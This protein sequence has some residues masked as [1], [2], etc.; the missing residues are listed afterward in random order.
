MGNVSPR[1]HASDAGQAAEHAYRCIREQILSGERSGGEWLREDGLAE[2]IGVSRTPVRE[3]L[4]HLAAEGLVLY[5][6]NR[7]VQVQTWTMS[8]LNEIYGLRSVLEPYGCRLAATSGR[9]DLEALSAMNSDM[10][11]AANATQPDLDR[12]TE[13]N[14]DFHRLIIDASGNARL[15]DLVTSNLQVPLVRHTFSRYSRSS[16]QRSMAHHRELVDA[17]RAE[18]PDWAESVM[19]SHVHAAW[20]VMRRYFDKSGPEA[21]TGQSLE[22]PNQPPPEEAAAVPGS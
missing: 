15:G 14:N 6:R 10:E 18:D 13:L 22:S 9:A 4:R 2:S 20:S 3:A 8:D 17:L 16:L 19:R 7:G 1:G 11:H 5:Q 21:A 12:V